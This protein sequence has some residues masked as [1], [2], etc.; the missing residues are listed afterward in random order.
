MPYLEKRSNKRRTY[1]VQSEDLYAALS[2]RQVVSPRHTLKIHGASVSV[3]TSLLVA[4]LTDV[5]TSLSERTKD[6]N[7]SQVEQLTQAVDKF[8]TAYR[9]QPTEQ[10]YRDMTVA[11][12]D[13][14]HRARSVV[15]QNLTSPDFG[16]QQLCRM[17]AMSRSKLYRHFATTGGVAAFIQRERLNAALLLLSDPSEARS[18]KDVAEALGFSDHST[19]SRAFRREFGFVPSQVKNRTSDLGTREADLRCSALPY[20]RH[21]KAS[22]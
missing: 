18:I 7:D 21:S 1:S 6:M 14:V 19:F 20:K 3:G 22:C 2:L 17:L 5:L 4:L 8:V 15:W 16:P 12:P 10:N 13:A 11:K 9:N